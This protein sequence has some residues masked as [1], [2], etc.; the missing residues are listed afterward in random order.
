MVISLASMQEVEALR[1]NEIMY[2]PSFT[3]SFNEWIEI[4]NDEASDI[5]LSNYTFC[6][7]TLLPGYIDR[8]ENLNKNEGIILKVGQYALITDGGSGTEVYD[9]FEVAPESLALHV[10][11]ST[12]CGGLTNS[13]KLIFLADSL[14]T[15]VDDVNYSDSAEKG[16]SLELYQ[17]SFL[18]SYEVGGTPG[19]ENSERQGENQNNNENNNSNNLEDDEETEI[20]EYIPDSYDFQ[21]GSEFLVNSSNY[22]KDKIILNSE[23]K[24]SKSFGKE[25]YS[26][27]NILRETIIYA[28]TIFCII[29]LV[30]LAARKL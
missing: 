26:K 1:I 10:S 15:I 28:F 17:G 6:N 22:K 8:Q 23:N 11:K 16:Y 5:D 27:Q 21:I 7:D 19:K 2:K 3:E 29:L 13:G 25:F 12:I 30:L 18:E 24:I 20:E 4:Y 14:G 9:N